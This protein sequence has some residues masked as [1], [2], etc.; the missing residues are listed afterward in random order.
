LPYTQNPTDAPVL[1]ACT[2]RVVERPGPVT[3]SVSTWQQPVP[4]DPSPAREAVLQHVLDRVLLLGRR[5]LRIGVDGFT[6]AGKTSFGHEPA[7][8]TARTGRSVLRASLDDFKKPWRDRHL[9]DRESGEGYHRNAFDNAAVRRLLLEPAAPG[10]SGEVAL[11]SIDPL[12]QR[13]HSSV[14]SVAAE[15]AV[16]V[17]DGVFAFR[18]EIDDCW[19]LRVWLEVDADRSVQRGTHRD[20]GR[21]GA[22]ATALHRDRYLPAERLYVAEVDPLGRADVVID[23]NDFAAPRLLRG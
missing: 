9:Y 1:P 10:G 23:N 13:D 11:C 22:E 4:P 3:L 8:R 18:P 6:A 12:T 20:G 14:V 5:R 2:V 7:V 15:D 19:D 17:V 21:V 16:L